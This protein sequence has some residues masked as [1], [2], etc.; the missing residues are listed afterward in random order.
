MCQCVLTL[1]LKE[2]VCTN[3]SVQECSKFTNNDQIKNNINIRISH[4]LGQVSQTLMN[5]LLKYENFARGDYLNMIWIC[6][7]MKNNDT[8]FSDISSV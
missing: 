4:P 6:A 5:T 3:N 7:I 8:P 2:K 1:N